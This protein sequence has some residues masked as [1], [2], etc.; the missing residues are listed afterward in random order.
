MVCNLDLRL[1]LAGAVLVCCMAMPV[2]AQSA[3]P[4]PQAFAAVQAPESAIE[5]CHAAS[6]Q[7]ALDCARR[8][9]QRKAT[10][11]ACFAVTVCEPSGW[12]GVMGVQLT[13]VHFSNVVCGAPTR[14]AA[15]A[16]LRAFCEGHTGFKQ[17]SLTRMWAPDGK[18]LMLDVT[19]TPA[20]FKK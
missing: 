9:C 12:S 15:T 13:E 19:W 4:V 7:A 16:S 14:E 20:D 11:G 10:R 3:K 8:R 1:L 5:V 18:L 6:A 2:R 17:C